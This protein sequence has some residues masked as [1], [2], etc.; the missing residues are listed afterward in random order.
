MTNQIPQHIAIYVRL[1]RED[2]DKPES[3]SIH[4]QIL[5]IKA[6]IRTHNDFSKYTSKIY[7]DDGYTGT[8]F[9]RPDFKQMIQDIEAEKISIVIVKDLSRLGRNMPKVTEL[10]QDYFPSRKIR[11][12]A[13][14][15]NIDKKYFAFDSSEDMMI[16]MKNMLNGFYPKD[17]SKKVRSSFRAKQSAGQFIGA[18]ACYGY[19]KDP[20]DHNHL[21]IDETASKNVRKIF[22]LFLSGKGQ[23]TIAKL[24]NEA[25]VPCPSQYKKLCGSNY[26]NSNKLE[27]TTYWTYSSIRN[28]LKNR[29][30]TGCMVQNTHFRQV[31]KKKAVKLPE[32]E[33]I[34]VENTHEAIIDK[35]TFNT[36]QKLLMNNT[37]Q[38]HLK[39][40]THIFAG[41]I[42]CG[43]CGRA[44]TK[45]TR[46]GISSFCCGSYNR[47]GKSHCSAHNIAESVLSE[48]IKNDLN[49][50][51]AATPS[52]EDMIQKEMKKIEN[53]NSAKPEEIPH[54]EAQ[55]EK[56]KR[57]K[58]RAYEDYTEELITKEE[59]LRYRSK[60]DHLSEKIKQQIACLQPETKLHRTNHT[61]WLD[62]LLRTGYINELDRE[63]VVEMVHMIYIFADDRIRIIYN[64]SDESEK[65]TA[66][67]KIIEAG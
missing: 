12:V 29:I 40:N 61:E 15:D 14:D 34:I 38:T 7:S 37:R 46:K 54:L 63:T 65:R 19:K 24:L 66:D 60:C 4:N 48:L 57:Q 10:V 58:N 18:F 64:F 39:Q 36:V 11:F 5:K 47:Y 3:D 26:C 22:A 30:Y 32:Q 2:G 28:I 53:A 23:N 42:K 9:E 6:Y 62:H 50:I 56:L 35:N 13:I 59:F 1:S 51:L 20:A 8:N 25:K 17:I 31:C 45:I 27:T 52:L 33:W 55:L 21:I 49:T 44:M 41:L 43:D 16:D 67:S